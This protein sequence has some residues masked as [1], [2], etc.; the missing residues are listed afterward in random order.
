MTINPDTSLLQAVF[1][2]H[3]VRSFKPVK[4]EER[5]LNSL[6]AEVSFAVSHESAIHFQLMTDDNSPFKGFSNSY[7]MFRNPYNYLACVV[8]GSYAFSLQK[9]GFYAE[10]FA[11]RAVGMGLGT[12]FVSGTFNARRIAAQLR[13]NWEIPFIVLVGYPQEAATTFM[14]KIMRKAAGSN[15]K[16]S[17]EEVLSQDSLS[18]QSIRERWPELITPLEAVACAPSALN[19]HPVRISIKE[20]QNSCLPAVS[21]SV[22]NQSDNSAIDLGIALANWQVAAGG[23]WEF[24]Q[25]PVWLEP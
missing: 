23:E 12:C 4:L 16:V 25:N 2:R 15:K 6:R 9:A 8:D 3:S 11:L 7:G 21:A 1:Q 13:V 20:Q 14:A 19:R 10:L 18:L 17:I 24:G 5:I 22:I